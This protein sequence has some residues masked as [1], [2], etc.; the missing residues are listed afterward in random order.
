MRTHT[1]TR[2]YTWI[3]LRVVTVQCQ[4]RL[5][6][7]HEAFALVW[8]VPVG[9]HQRKPPSCPPSTPDRGQVSPRHRTPLRRTKSGPSEGREGWTRT[10]QARPQAKKGDKEIHVQQQQYFEKNQ[11]L[12]YMRERFGGAK[13]ENHAL[14][15]MSERE[16]TTGTYKRQRQ[17]GRRA[18]ALR[19]CER[20]Q[21]QNRSFN[22]P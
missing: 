3:T 22:T 16:D 19:R 2:T 9:I 6:R 1:Y 5:S 17:M 15:E 20:G 11:I 12:H 7:P 4:V 8:F 10:N 13:Q 14:G 18:G 21:N